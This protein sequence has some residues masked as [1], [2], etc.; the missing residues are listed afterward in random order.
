MAI[1]D[2]PEFIEVAPGELIRADNWNSIQRQ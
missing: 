1:S 2:I